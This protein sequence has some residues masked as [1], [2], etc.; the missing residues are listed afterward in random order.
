MPQLPAPIHRLAITL[1]VFHFTV[2]QP[3]LMEQHWSLA[4]TQLI[5]LP[6]RF[7]SLPTTQ[8]DTQLVAVIWIMPMDTLSLL[9]MD[10]SWFQPTTM[11][12]IIMQ[13][14]WKA[15]PVALL[16]PRKKLSFCFWPNRCF[17]VQLSNKHISI[18]FAY[19]FGNIFV[20]KV[21]IG[22]TMKLGYNELGCYRTDF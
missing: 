18:S 4:G 13:E 19:N 12:L 7:P 2:M 16:L 17:L 15:T 20:E 14:R 6:L 10:M 22:N 21:L 9:D 1:M 3:T 11:L 8:L 5:H